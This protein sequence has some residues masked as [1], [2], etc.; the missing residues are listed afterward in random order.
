MCIEGEKLCGIEGEKLRGLYFKGG[1]GK[2][3]PRLD[4]TERGE[5]EERESRERERILLMRRA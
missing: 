2:N 5:R 4:L 1:W 3:T